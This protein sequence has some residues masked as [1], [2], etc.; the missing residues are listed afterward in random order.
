M[1][2]EEYVGAMD[3][4]EPSTRSTLM[5]VVA[6]AGRS[7]AHLDGGYAAEMRLMRRST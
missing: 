6:R 4:D 5:I 7:P 3:A 2:G 1:V